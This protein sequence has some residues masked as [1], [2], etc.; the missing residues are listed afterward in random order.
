[1]Y[2]YAHEIIISK[3]S[4]TAKVKV[5]EN[6]GTPIFMRFY[7]CLKACNDSFI[8]CRPII[9]LY[10]CFLKGKYGDELLT[11]IGRDVNDQMLP[12]VVEVGNKDTWT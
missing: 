5:E 1:M 2:D 9:G 8:S 7:T 3:L 4:S 10:G 12:I 6:D 11:T